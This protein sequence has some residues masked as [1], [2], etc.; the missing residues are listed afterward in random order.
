MRINR[1]ILWVVCLC[2][3]QSQVFAST[4]MDVYQQALQADPTYQIDVNT[5]R[6]A[7]EQ[8]PISQAKLLPDIDVV[9]SLTHSRTHKKDP[10]STSS[11][12]TGVFALDVSQPLFDVADA[13]ALQSAKASVRAAKAQ[14]DA[15]SQTLVLR[16]AKAYF[17]V[18]EAHD[19]WVYSQSQS[20]ALAK[21]L[22]QTEQRFQVGLDAITAVQEVRAQYDSAL[23]SQLAAANA[24]TN[25]L[26]DLRALTNQKY[27]S[28]ASLPADQLP[29][30][31]PKPAGLDAWVAQA[32]QHNTDVI[33]AMANADAAHETMLAAQANHLPVLSATGAYTYTHNSDK[34][35]SVVQKTHVPSVGLRVTMPVFSGG[36]ISAAARQAAYNAALAASTTVQITRSVVNET[37]QSYLGVLAGISQVKATRQAVRSSLSTL[38]S[39]REAY[40]VGTRVLTDVLTAQANLYAAQQDY[41]QQQYAYLLSM[42]NLKQAAGSLSAN[43][44]SQISKWFT[45]RV[46]VQKY[47]QQVPLSEIKRISMP[48]KMASSKAQVGHVGAATGK[49]T[50]TPGFAHMTAPTPFD[51]TMMPGPVVLPAPASNFKLP[52][53]NISQAVSP[54][55]VVLPEPR[56]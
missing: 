11:T 20:K 37:R 8:V 27:T 47:Y 23:A 55:R 34:T 9:G 18:L 6:A 42:L 48:A 31:V 52:V 3:W 12:E 4:I 28:L 33:A 45:G 13:K 35:L 39:T 46:Q 41:A 36:A 17:A 2:W 40:Q 21:Q 19:M 50:P 1:A 56:L 22:Q 14:Y 53:P 16:V 30:V 32:R 38:H 26:E 7:R 10:D 25:A 5:Y 54:G 49:H 15:A 51:I 43:D 24:L 44:L 29:L